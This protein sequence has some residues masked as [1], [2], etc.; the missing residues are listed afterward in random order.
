MA[1][2]VTKEKIKENRTSTPTRLKEH[3]ERSPGM[4]PSGTVGTGIVQRYK[5]IDG[6]TFAQ[7]PQ[8][9]EKPMVMV[10]SGEPASI[11]FEESVSDIGGQLKN[12][13]IE[14]KENEKDNNNPVG[15]FV[16]YGQGRIPDVRKKPIPADQKD[17]PEMPQPN[18]ENEQEERAK[19]FMN[20]Q[21]EFVDE[22]LM[23][24]NN[25]CENTEST[26]IK[27]ISN[28][29]IETTSHLI[30]W[31]RRMSAPDERTSVSDTYIGISSLGYDIILD[32]FTLRTV[33]CQLGDHTSSTTD[34]IINDYQELNNQGANYLKDP[35]KKLNEYSVEDR[36]KDSKRALEIII[37][38]LTYRKRQ[39]NEEIKMS[40]Y[41]PKLPTGCG[42]SA[43]RRRE[44]GACKVGSAK[45]ED[46]KPE[47]VHWNYHYATPISLPSGLIGP[48]DYLFIE[49]A[50]GK[51]TDEIELA[52]AHWA[53]HIYG[54]EEKDAASNRQENAA[55][56][57]YEDLD[58]R[59]N[60]L[61]EGLKSIF[62]DI[63]KIN[64]DSKLN[65][66]YTENDTGLL[67]KLELVFQDNQDKQNI[68]LKYKYQPATQ[69][70]PYVKHFLLDLA[71]TIADEF[72]LLALNSLQPENLPEL[73]SI[74]LKLRAFHEAPSRIEFTVEDIDPKKIKIQLNRIAKL[75]QK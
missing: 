57:E 41:I 65:M 26:E 59:F 69:D 46:N 61:S 45:F 58:C 3:I 68:R 67:G 5:I 70:Y 35:I 18:R 6:R 30:C 28:Q 11:Y 66:E 75:T 62:Y 14:K 71:K 17:A 13:G 16:R 48:N 50:V 52:N 73:E 22:L 2:F 49:D 19:K 25:L 20:M 32:L 33:A 72:V 60:A 56:K 27:K 54:C 40:P 34:S 12:L 9:K 53:A 63:N 23:Q 24:A 7:A 36:K 1:D 55:E 31:Y 8:G 64:Q 43:E 10:K 51:S 37:E 42:M 29:I 15:T 74:R 39:I 44:L 4:S 47:V 38:D 21:S